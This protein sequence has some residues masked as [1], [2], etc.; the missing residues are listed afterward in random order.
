MTVTTSLPSVS[1]AASA[2]DRLH[3]QVRRWI[4][5]QGWDELRDVQARTI[6]AVLDGNR[7]VLISASTAAGKTEAAFLPALT[8]VAERSERGLSILYVSP[9][10]ALINDQFRR[11]EQLCEQMEIGVVRW[12][13]DAPQAAKA[14]L[15]RKPEGIALITPESIE[16]LLIRRSRD[17][18]GLLG[19]LDFIIIDELHAFMQGARGLQLAS[20]LHRIDVLS[21]KRA[22]RIGLSATLGD[23]S[24]AAQWLNP[25][26][27]ESVA[28]VESAADGAELKLQI[29]GYVRADDEKGGDDLE[30]EVHPVALDLVADHAFMVLRGKNNLVFGGSRRSVEALADRL[31][32]RSE[33]AD[34]PNEFFP[35][36][37]SLAKELRES[38]EVRLKQDALPTTAVA[39]TTLELGIDIGSVA[40]VAT[41][42]APR[43]LGALRQRL[44]R[45][46]RRK[47]APAVLRV[48]VREP[49]LSSDLNPLEQLRLETVRAVAATRLLVQR[50]VEPPRRDPALASTALHQTLSIIAERGGAKADALFAAV[51]SP[52]PFAALT[53]ADYVGMLRWMANPDVR[54]IEQAPDG[55]IMLGEI[56]ERLVGGRDFYAVF[57]SDEEWRLVASGRTLGVIPLSNI[58]GVGSL[59]VFAGQ[60][61]RIVAVDEAAKVLDVVS[62]R[63]G[64]LPKFD[65]LSLEPIHD[66]LSAEMLAV[67]R[68]DDS[69]PYLDKVAADFLIEGRAAFQG[70]GLERRRLIEF[71]RDTHVLTWR[72][73]A[74]NGVFAVV[75]ASSGLDCEAHDIGVTV[76]NATATEVSTIIGAISSV[77]DLDALAAKVANLRQAKYDAFVPE[78]LLRKG[79]IQSNL[80]AC[81]DIP[82]LLSEI[83]AAVN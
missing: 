80:K 34:V 43:S 63:A 11:L 19:S 1:D 33:Q 68:G 24:M 64:T 37:G 77:P 5:D 61:W 71:H 67:Y 59:L 55:T 14:R 52:G 9:L 66:R 72:G 17:A 31:R 81:E 15:F 53:R 23:L 35:H 8:A 26:A 44:G 3:P 21:G 69:A 4:R 12:H 20:L 50:F 82:L 54:L 48:Y 78:G 73:S 49:R 42:G 57:E 51:C 76:A 65:R 30:D 32:R 18:Q 75:L 56:G 62:H 45:S 7:D 39:T 13:G 10:K 74:T 40:S 27:P 60:R 2:F 28:V 46:G 36:H 16:A 70:L 29:R 38:L 83:R 58:V 6:A 47:G 22:R 25:E 41:L 79:W